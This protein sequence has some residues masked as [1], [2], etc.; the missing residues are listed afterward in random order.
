MRKKTYLYMVLILFVLSGCQSQ[1]RKNVEGNSDL[2]MFTE[3][4]RPLNFEKNGEITGQATEVVTEL[5]RRTGTGADIRLVPW[6]E[7]YQKVLDQPNTAIFSTVMTPERK[8]LFQWVGPIAVL[9]TNLYALKGSDINITSMADVKDV[10]EVATVED[11]YTEDLLQGDHGGSNIKTY[12][13]EAKTAR[14]L[15]DGDAQLLASS[16]ES[17]PNVLDKIDADMDRVK[18]VFTVST[19]LAYIAFSNGTPSDLV[20]DWQ[21]KLNQMKEDGTFAQIYSEWFPKQTPPGKLQMVTEDYPPITFMQNGKPAGLVTDMVKEIADRL[22]ISTNI[23][24][25][26]W[27]NAYNMALVHPNVILF[28]AARTEERED[29]FH[30]VGPA[31]QNKAILYAKEGS[32]IQVNSLEEAK[33]VDAIATTADWWTQKY[34]KDHGFTNLVSSTEPTANVQQLMNGEVQLS[35]F[36]DLTVSKIVKNAGY[37]MDDMKPVLTVTKREFYIAISKGTS[38]EMVEKWR[39][40]LSEIKKDGTFAEIY[41][42]YL[43]RVDIKGLLEQ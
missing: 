2:T 39:S 24:L 27:K 6:Q 25:T 21:E 9:E 28:S 41:K 20:T 35:I 40:T 42:D 18:N 38:P 23:K 17:L 15:L 5:A 16:N 13:D 36:T 22:D 19:D 3:T 37:S 30:W 29:K 43:P 34:L 31:G 8:E 33:N 1:L 14:A 12:P 26:S 11:Y 7:G 10:S 4:Y 32:D